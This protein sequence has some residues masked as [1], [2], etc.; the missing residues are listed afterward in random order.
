MFETFSSF[1]WYLL[2]KKRLNYKNVKVLKR[3]R[4]VHNE[5][6]ITPERKNASHN[7]RIFTAC[8]G[9]FNIK[10]SGFESLSKSDSFIFWCQGFDE[11]N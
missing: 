10:V 4:Y 5:E 9:D 3:V 2:R 7:F 6:H 8:H 11:K 1:M